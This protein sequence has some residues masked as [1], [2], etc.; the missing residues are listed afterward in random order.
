MWSG[1]ARGR[2]PVVARSLGRSKGQCS[3]AAFVEDGVASARRRVDGARGGNLG[4]DGRGV[5][6]VLSGR[7]GPNGRAVT[8]RLERAN[9]A[10]R[11]EADVDEALSGVALSLSTL[12]G[13]GRDVCSPALRLALQPTAPATMRRRYSLRLEVSLWLRRCRA[14]PQPGGRPT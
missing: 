11:R 7:P 3:A 13:R 6:A 8:R 9:Y 5:E 2:V 10:G 1:R 4:P 14:R 12:S